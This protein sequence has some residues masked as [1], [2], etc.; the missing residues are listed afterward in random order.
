VIYLEQQSHNV[1]KVVKQSPQVCAIASVQWTQHA[2]ENTTKYY[3][4]NKNAE[5]YKHLESC[6]P[7]KSTK[8]MLN[9]RTPYGKS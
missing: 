4:I 8:C 3:R 1:D 5:T 2:E 9:K 7:K 6:N